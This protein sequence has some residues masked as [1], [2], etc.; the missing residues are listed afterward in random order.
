ML[1]SALSA[2]DLAGRAPALLRLLRSLLLLGARPVC[3]LG[4]KQ[5][6]D[7][8]YDAVVGH[9]VRLQDFDLVDRHTA[10]AALTSSVAP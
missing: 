10:F 8:M 6:A 2:T 9:D 7:D 3:R 4:G 1:I 5:P